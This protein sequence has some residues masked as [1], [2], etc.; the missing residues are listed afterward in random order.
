[1]EKAQKLETYSWQGTK[2]HIDFGYCEVKHNDKNAIWWTN[3]E[4]SLQSDGIAIIP[5]VRVNYN[6]NSF[7]LS[8]HFGI[9]IHKLQ[10]GGWPN[11]QH[12]S[13]SDAAFTCT[14]NSF[15]NIKQF[16]E[17]QFKVRE[18]QRREWQRKTHPKEFAQMEALLKVINTPK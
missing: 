13:L 4:C 3:Y 18:K 9:A 6:G 8:N 1:V 16:N 12:F 15:Y 10:N 17:F 5:A 7:V 14:N 2:V 11:M